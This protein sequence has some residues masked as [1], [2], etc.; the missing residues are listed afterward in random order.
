MAD[1]RSRKVVRSYRLVFCRRW[2]IFRIQNWRIPLPGGLELRAIAY[3][4]LCLGTL[5][6][7][8]RVPLVGAAVAALPPSL[9]LLAL[10]VLAA[11]G[12]SRWELDGRSPH[13]A[14][15][16]LA[17]WRARPRTVAALRRCPPEGTVLPIP[18]SVLSAPDLQGPRYPRGRIAGPCRLL[19]RYPVAAR[20]ELVPRGAGQGQRERL[21]A[22]R[23]LCL[24]RAEGPPLH[25]AAT[26]TVPAGKEVVFE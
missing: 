5:G 20:A 12:L 9:R 13:R 8:A 4:L 18:A 2:R 17:L 16:G 21:A 1:E 26:L 10:P 7:L 22:A 15:L 19:L 11:W 25:R 14:L 3:W 24:R 6:L 23:R